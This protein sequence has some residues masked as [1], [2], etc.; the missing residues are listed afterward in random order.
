MTASGTSGPGC[1]YNNADQIALTA[2]S[3]ARQLDGYCQPAPHRTLGRPTATCSFPTKIRRIT[4]SHQDRSARS[5]IV[6]NCRPPMAPPRS[7][8][9]CRAATPP[10]WAAHRRRSATGFQSV[11]RRDDEVVSN[12]YRIT[13][14]AK[15][16]W[17]GWDMDGGY[18]HSENHVSFEGRK[19]TSTPRPWSRGD[20]QCRLLQLPESVV[21]AG[22]QCRP[23]RHRTPTVRPVKLDSVDLK[24]SGPLFDSAGRADENGRGLGSFA[25]SRLTL[26][27]GAASAAGDGVE[28]QV[29]R[30][31]SP[32]AP[33]TRRSANSISQS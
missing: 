2:G 20:R 28:H 3:R 4:C 32:V 16:T 26:Q 12:T 6:L 22:R 19:T 8:I 14:G 13:V 33:F 17:Y 15:G 18:G 29:S 1:Y 24:G 23:E 11:G 31:L 10:A 21:D 27:P 7:R 5:S 25:A 9:S 30:G